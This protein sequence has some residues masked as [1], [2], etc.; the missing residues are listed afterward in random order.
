MDAIAESAHTGWLAR[1]S[2]AH[3]SA[4]IASSEI[5]VRQRWRRKRFIV[6]TTL[7]Q[8]AGRGVDVGQTTQPDPKWEL[9]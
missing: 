6:E 1:A 7:T 3:T 5:G 9:A 2:W 8:V 4:S